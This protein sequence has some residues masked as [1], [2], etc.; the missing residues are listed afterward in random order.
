[1]DLG[2]KKDGQDRHWAGKGQVVVDEDAQEEYERIMGRT[3]GG[4]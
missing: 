2:R 1:L 3:P 4:Q